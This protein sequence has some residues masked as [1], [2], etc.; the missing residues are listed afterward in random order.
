MSQGTMIG[1]E[2]HVEEAPEF[3]T[4]KPEGLGEDD[5]APIAPAKGETAAERVKRIISGEKRNGERPDDVPNVGASAP[6]SSRPKRDRGPAPPKPRE[7][8]L[9]K[10]LTDVYT[11]IGLMI[12][13]VDSVCSTAFISNAEECARSV[14]KLARENEA[15]RRVVVRMLETSA[16]GGVIVAH[17]PILLMITMHHGPETVKE[18]IAPV[19]AMMN[20]GAMKAAEEARKTRNEKTSAEGSPQ[21]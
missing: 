7:G 10:P 20:P 2:F 14:E 4:P 21:K 15:V 18:R 17:L 8:S 16:W 9:V 12:A 19:A 3:V 11:G 6:R 5:T 1:G 13:P